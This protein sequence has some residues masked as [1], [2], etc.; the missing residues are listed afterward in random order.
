MQLWRAKDKHNIK[1]SRAWGLILIGVTRFEEA[2]M[3]HSGDGTLAEN[4]SSKARY[5]KRRKMTLQNSAPHY[6]YFKSIKEL[7]P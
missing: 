2:K 7:C 1:W 6:R 3:P 5:A 4:A